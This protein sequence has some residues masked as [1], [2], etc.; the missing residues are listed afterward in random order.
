MF[1]DI[2]N[3]AEGLLYL[4]DGETLVKEKPCERAL[5]HITFLEGTIYL[6]KLIPNRACKEPTQV[7][8]VRQINS[9][10][11]IYPGSV[12]ENLIGFNVNNLFMQEKP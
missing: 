2:D 4:D 8:L 1:L 6:T 12:A 7:D 3:K 9:I 11:I 10:E 5:V